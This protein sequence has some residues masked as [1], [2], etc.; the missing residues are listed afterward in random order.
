MLPVVEWLVHVFILHWKPRRV[1]PLTLDP[2]LAR[3]HRL[4]HADPR[5]IPLV[6]IPWQAQAVARA[7]LDR[8]GLAGHAHL[9]VDVHA[10]GGDLHHQVRL[11]VDPLPAA[12]RLPAEVGVVPQGLAQ[13]PAAPLQE[14][15]LLVH[16]HH[17]RYGGPALRH[18]AGPEHGPHLADR[19]APARP[20]PVT[21]PRDKSSRG[22]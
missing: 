6:F 7:R 17:G 14:R 22:R 2:L 21:T 20:V 5:A 8:A 4:H 11:R 3:K 15:A 13:P 18:R 16:R 9:D 12:Q 10:A 1:G 19:P